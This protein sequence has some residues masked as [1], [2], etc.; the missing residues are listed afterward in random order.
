[1]S[2]ALSNTVILSNTSNLDMFSTTLRF[3]HGTSSLKLRVSCGSI[4]ATAF[5]K[6]FRIVRVLNRVNRKIYPCYSKV[7]IVQCIVHGHSD[8]KVYIQNRNRA[9]V[10]SSTDISYVCI[11]VTAKT[12]LPRYPPPRHSGSL[13]DPIPGDLESAPLSASVLSPAPSQLIFPWTPR[14]RGS[15]TASLRGTLCL[16]RSAPI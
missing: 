12:V 8:G 3:H 16:V 10:H 4:P 14:A 6:C 2:F 1:M 7:I 5:S 9:C 11:Y 13:S 15:S